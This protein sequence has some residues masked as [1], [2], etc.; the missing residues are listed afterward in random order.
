MNGKSCSNVVTE[1]EFKPHCGACPCVSRI[2]YTGPEQGFRLL[3]FITGQANI[4]TEPHF[5]ISS[6]H[7]ERG[8]DPATL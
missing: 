2:F 5:D 4:D 1:G 6:S 3:V 7:K 8:D